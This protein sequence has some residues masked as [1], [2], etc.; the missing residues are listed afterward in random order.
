MAE[1][2]LTFDA[3]LEAL[4][5]KLAWKM[6]AGRAEESGSVPVKPRLLNVDQAAVYLGRSK[7]AI[8]HLITSGK[9]PTVRTDRRVFIDVLDLD[10]LIEENKRTGI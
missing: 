7:E 3:V 6:R 9:I 10:R 1:N 2:K 5:D 4:A 8:Q